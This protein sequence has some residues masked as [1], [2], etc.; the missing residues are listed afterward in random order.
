MN[1]EDSEDDEDSITFSDIVNYFPYLKS[2]ETQ[3][4]EPSDYYLN[5]TTY[6]AYEE[7]Q[8]LAEL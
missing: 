7:R 1:S 3:K 6:A 8:R 5:H 4:L 2:L